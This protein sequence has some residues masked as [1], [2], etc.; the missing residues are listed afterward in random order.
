MR[1]LLLTNKEESFQVS[2][3]DIKGRLKDLIRV[4]KDV[5][6]ESID[7]TIWNTSILPN[8]IQQTTQPSPGSSG[9]PYDFIRVCTKTFYDQ[10]IKPSPLDPYLWL[11]LLKPNGKLE[12]TN[13]DNCS[14]TVDDDTPDK[15]EI[16]NIAEV[17]DLLFI[18]SEGLFTAKNKPEDPWPSILKWACKDKGNYPLIKL[19]LDVAPRSLVLMFAMA[20]VT[21]EKIGGNAEKMHAQEILKI[22][23]SIGPVVPPVVSRDLCSQIRGLYWRRNSCYMDTSLHCMLAVPSVLSH[24]ILN[25]N[26]ET[27]II[28]V[29]GVTPALDLI[30]RRRVQTELRYITETIRGKAKPENMAATADKLRLLFR[31]CDLPASRQWWTGQTQEAGELI[32][33]LLSL[34]PIDLGIAV[35]KSY[36]TNNIKLQD[37]SKMHQTA[38]H[39]STQ[40]SP[41]VSIYQHD[42][43]S[44][45]STT[46]PISDFLTDI[47]DSG[48]LEAK[49]SFVA[50][51]G[52]KEE[53][54]RR[55]V[56][57]KKLFKAP[58]AIIFNT[59]RGGGGEHPLKLVGG[60]AE[61]W[62]KTPIDPDEYITL[63][64]GQRFEFCGVILYD[65]G[66][67]TCCYNCTNI[68][69]YYDDLQGRGDLSIPTE[70][71]P[72]KT[73]MS[74]RYSREIRTRGTV[75]FYK[76]IEGP[77]GLPVPIEKRPLG[78]RKPMGP[79][80]LFIPCTGKSEEQCIK[81]DRCDWDGNSK[82][83]RAIDDE[84]H[85]IYGYG[86]ENIREDE[87]EEDSSEGEE[88]DSSDGDVL[89]CLGEDFS[90]KKSS[91]M[92][93][94]E[95]MVIDEDEGTPENFIIVSGHAAP[96]GNT[97]LVP[98]RVTI[99]FSTAE[100]DVEFLPDDFS[101]TR[102]QARV[103]LEAENQDIEGQSYISGFQCPDYDI[104]FDEAN[105]VT[106]NIFLV[107][108]LEELHDDRGYE[109]LDIEEVV[110]ARNDNGQPENTTLE[111]IANRYSAATPVGSAVSILALF[112]RGGG[113]APGQYDNF[114][115]G[116]DDLDL[117]WQDFGGGFGGLG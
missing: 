72:Y 22:I 94:D 57:I 4:G 27:P 41:V 67:Y 115:A 58:G 5:D 30:N 73:L 109:P 3:G 63:D 91:S 100:G 83:C 33:W 29:C 17:L 56:R 8:W 20:A 88:E 101:S 79:T 28:P 95:G 82:V 104:Y 47:Q 51:V 31:T 59:H 96:T 18:P 111:D 117:D 43:Q 24:F 68:W 38:T 105:A 2:S 103:A 110:V 107:R 32:S 80:R 12:I 1:I 75:Y 77:S 90:P 102:M 112:C 35:R 97:F 7:S 6:V 16:A 19:V 108:N 39:I 49:Y 113:D 69:Y 114:A 93:M 34:F 48:E 44:K 25:V 70:I 9:G 66:H 26:L 86:T 81:T 45:G 36:A 87:E 37:V 60:A 85:F 76:Q 71:G 11:K 10:N 62:I 61:R 23:S 21:A 13:R 116:F 55:S 65:G 64:S 106:H 89:E 84:G 40:E 53:S 52:D 54:F 15:I 42:L 14:L 78:P 46:T 98:P 50:T 92:M 99:A 74:G